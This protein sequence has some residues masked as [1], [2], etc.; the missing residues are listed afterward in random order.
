MRRFSLLFVL[1][2]CLPLA[3]FSQTGP[4][5]A[6]LETWGARPFPGAIA[7]LPLSIVG[8]TSLPA[9]LSAALEATYALTPAKD[10]HGVAASAI[11][12]GYPQWTG[13][14]GTSDGVT[15]MSPALSFEIGSCTKTFI[16]ALI[17]ELRD[18]GKLALT[19]SISQISSEVFRM[20]I[21][22]LRLKNCLI[23]PAASTII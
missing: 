21:A 10:K 1:V 5:R 15:A 13:A 17:L 7:A 22:R 6:S 23:T 20:S 18:E 14:A 3:A 8:D 9:R 19:D 11:V 16:A 2:A 12:P 4:N